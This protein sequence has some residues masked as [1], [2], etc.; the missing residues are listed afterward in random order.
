MSEGPATVG[1]W[2][3]ATSRRASRAWAS[4]ASRRTRALGESNVP[5][6]GREELGINGSTAEKK[7]R[8]VRRLRDRPLLREAFRRG[9]ITPRKA[10]I[11]VRVPAGDQEA[12]WLLRA[13]TETVRALS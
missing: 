10:E 13:K 5:D 6:N 9:E 2:T 4:T 11:I 7:V 1:R 12:H 3:A 8:L